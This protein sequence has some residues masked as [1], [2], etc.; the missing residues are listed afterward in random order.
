[1]PVPVPQIVEWIERL[2]D[3]KIRLEAINHHRPLSG[4]P[5]EP[6]PS[7]QVQVQVRNRVQRVFTD[8]EH[9]AIPALGDPLTLRHLLG[10]LEHLRHHHRVPGPDDTGVSDV[11]AGHDEHVRWTN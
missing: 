11:L 6:P 8:V 4:R 5:S 3:E 9:E 10:Q 1:M 2:I 7:E